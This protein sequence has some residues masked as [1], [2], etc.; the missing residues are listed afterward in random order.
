MPTVH[1]K[2]RALIAVEGADAETFLQN[3]ITTD[4]AALGE[5]EA[6][7]S[8][9]L[10]PQGKILFDFLVSRAGDDALPARLPRRAGRR[11]RAPADALQAARQ[12][13]DRQAR[14]GACRGLVGR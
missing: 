4:L 14:S 1:L 12:G 9:L 5:G 3:I 8:A 7:A 13:D 6:R 11:F 2:D 10:S